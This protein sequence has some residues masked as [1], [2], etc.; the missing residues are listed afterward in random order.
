MST[1]RIREVQPLVQMYRQLMDDVWVND[2]L[3]DPK[4]Y[5]LNH[6]V[7]LSVKTQASKPK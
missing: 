6:L 4:V 2:S 5:R 1:L 3:F 7:I